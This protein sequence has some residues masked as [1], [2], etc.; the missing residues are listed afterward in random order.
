[1]S[2]PA[3]V[4]SRVAATL[5]G[6]SQQSIY[7]TVAK[8]DVE[9]YKDDSGKLWLS[10]DSLKAYSEREPRERGRV[11]CTWNVEAAHL[12][13]AAEQGASASRP[14]RPPRT[15]DGWRI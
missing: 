2:L 5:L 1:M 8:G 6:I 10:V 3:L 14:P 13:L 11:Q 4:S 7:R 12:A 9:S 15:R